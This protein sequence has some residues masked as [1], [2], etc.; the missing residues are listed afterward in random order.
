MKRN[1]IK[2]KYL[3]NIKEEE[4]NINDE[5]K[6]ITSQI[7]AALISFGWVILLSI[8][9]YIPL[10]FLAMFGIDY[11][12]FSY[13]GKILYTIICSVLFLVF[14]IFIYRKELITNAKSFF[15]KN[16]ISNLEVPVKYWLVGLL[17]M[18]GSNLFI[19]IIT[20]GRVASNEESVR[21]LID[22]MPLYMVFQ[23]LIYA[24]ITEEL[25]FRK[26]IR[27]I[28]NNKYLYIL[29][30]GIVFGGL[31]VITSVSTITDLLYIVPYSALGIA[32]AYTYTKTNNIF[33][34]IS[35]HALHNS[36]TLILFFLGRSV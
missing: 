12:N 19:S 2:K 24:P 28:F 20:N 27:N 10:I 26:S 35:M 18:I 33:S 7:K 23:I 31:H 21:E 25:I 16:F 29:T 15:N 13:N 30:S 3:T 17:V 8:Y 9:S 6:D 4:K 34:T 32:F 1:K 22:M 5:E 11:N 14:I 36:L